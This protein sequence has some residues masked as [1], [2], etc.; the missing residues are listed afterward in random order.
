MH[1]ENFWKGLKLRDHTFW[2]TWK[3][4]Q[5]Y[6]DVGH[7]YLEIGPGKFPKI[8]TE[9]NTFLDE[10]ESAIA[11][12]IAQGGQGVVGD[13]QETF[14]FSKETFDGVCAFEVL[15]HLP[16]HEKTFQEIARVLKP[17]GRFVFSVPLRMR[18]WSIWDEWA[19]HCRRY[20]PQDL[21]QLLQ[22]YDFVPQDVFVLRSIYTNILLNAR[23]VL[24]AAYGVRKFLQGLSPSVFSISHNFYMTAAGFL[25]HRLAS[26]RRVNELGEVPESE[27][28]VLVVCKKQ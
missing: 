10:S 17:G 26:F 7:Q 25:S 9:G 14:S 23:P 20:E 11:A 16:N 2:F 19:G 8:P 27:A 4:I 18:Y 22:R 28:H 13:V 5:N 1:Y 24:W 12:I 15:E 6:L 21:D 3:I